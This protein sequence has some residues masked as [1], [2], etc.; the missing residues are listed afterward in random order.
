MSQ[1]RKR[2]R[3]DD[4]E[5]IRAAILDELEKSNGENIHDEE[6]DPSDVDSDTDPTFHL[7]SDHD[8][9][10]EQSDHEEDDHDQSGAQENQIY[11][12]GKKVPSGRRIL[13]H[14]IYAQ[15]AAIL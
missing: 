10:S 13:H 1:V 14:G 4:E 11:F 6:Y 12:V 3:W 5:G 2:F 8:S 9:C 15:E 7:T